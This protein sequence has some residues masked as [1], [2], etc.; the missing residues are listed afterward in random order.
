MGHFLF[1]IL[2][3][4]VIRFD[5]WRNN[6]LGMKISGL[7][8]PHSLNA[9]YP[10]LDSGLPILACFGSPIYTRGYRQEG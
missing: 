2:A 7:P 9:S 1:F 4:Q 6:T 8:L 10:E 5:R 3:V